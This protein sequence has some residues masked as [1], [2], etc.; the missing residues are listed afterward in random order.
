[1]AAVVLSWVGGVERVSDSFMII[2]GREDLG[3]V[4]N[5]DGNVLIS[6]L[7]IDDMAYFAATVSCGLE[8]K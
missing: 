4:R 5:G 2:G 6:L 8:G 3:G 1:M 7:Y